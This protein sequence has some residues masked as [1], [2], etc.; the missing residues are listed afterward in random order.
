VVI[1]GTDLENQQ[2]SLSLGDG[3]IATNEQRDSH[4]IRVQVKVAEEASQ[5]RGTCP[6]EAFGAL[7][8][9][10]IYHQIDQIEVTPKLATR[11][12]AVGKLSRVAQ[13]EAIGSTRLASGELLS[14]GAVP[15][16]WNVVPF[17]TDGR[18]SDDYKLAGQGKSRG[19]YY[20]P[21]L[22]R[23]QGANLACGCQRCLGNRRKVG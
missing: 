1:I 23:N 8:L 22:T 7:G 15:V 18:D 13:F 16:E 9:L 5:E 6:W 21:I 4:S 17:V 12:S 19:R 20:L 11:A 3:V 10:A 14:L 2:G